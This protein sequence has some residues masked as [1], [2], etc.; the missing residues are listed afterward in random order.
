MLPMQ[1]AQVQYL[2]GETQIAQ[3]VQHGQTKEIQF[4]K[5]IFLRSS[6]FKIL[7]LRC[8]FNMLRENVKKMLEI[9][10]GICEKDLE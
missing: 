1:G 8:L 10:F 9:Q 6:L 5:K 7:Q 2:T 4:K 3:A